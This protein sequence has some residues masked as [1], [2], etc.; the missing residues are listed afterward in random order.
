MRR[1][2][3]KE[4]LETRWYTAGILAIVLTILLLGDP[5]AYQTGGFASSWFLLPMAATFLMGLSGYSRETSGGTMDFIFSRPIRWWWLLLA[6]AVAGAM[7][8]AGVSIIS[9]PV[10]L[11]RAPSVYRPFLNASGLA[12][13]MTVLWMALCAAYLIGLL[14][15]SIVPGVILTVA[16][17][18]V[19]LTV[20]VDLSDRASRVHSEPW[21]AA[22][23]I[24]FLLIAAVLAVRPPLALAPRRRAWLWARCF[25][26]GMAAMFASAYTLRDMGWDP[27]ISRRLDRFQSPDRQVNVLV[28]NT[29]PGEVWIDDSRHGRRQVDRADETEAI[30]WTPYGRTYYY[31]AVV[32]GRVELRS[33]SESG[34]W[35]P[36]TACT[37]GPE[38]QGVR[39]TLED[40]FISSGLD[41]S[42]GGRRA[43]AEMYDYRVE[44]STAG[45]YRI[46][47]IDLERHRV[48][49]LRSPERGHLW[50]WWIDDNHL[51]L[52]GNHFNVTVTE[53]WP[54]RPRTPGSSEVRR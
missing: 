36:E 38:E 47:V 25:A 54:E 53:A 50:H 2:I 21:I 39:R 34:G 32:R 28:G 9:L 43:A 7:A 41:F 1:L 24:V 31:T 12:E 26:L 17:V 3:T 22:V 33:I 13:G 44:H 27:Q 46:A 45:P 5:V 19:G 42:P 8:L 40:Y 6:K 30:G 15:S 35:N 16:V 11:L 10:Y 48:R 20:W 18:L 52:A 4:L 51:A 29:T 37:L 14:L 23:A 49:Y